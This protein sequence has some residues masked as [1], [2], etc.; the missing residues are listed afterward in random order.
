MKHCT[1]LQRRHPSLRLNLP[2]Q[3]RHQHRQRNQR[4]GLEGEGGDVLSDHAVLPTSTITTMRSMKMMITTRTSYHHRGRHLPGG[5]DLQVNLAYPT[6]FLPSYPLHLSLSLS[7]LLILLVIF[8]HFMSSLAFAPRRGTLID[9][10][11]LKVP[12]T[13]I[14]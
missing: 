13:T 6:L 8:V 14:L 10:G 9:G 1:R 4:G 3:Q 12:P 7:L 11:L 5:S 2:Q